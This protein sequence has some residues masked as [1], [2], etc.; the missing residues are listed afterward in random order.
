MAERIKTPVT[1][2]RGEIYL[3][4]FDPVRGREIAKTRPALVIQNNIGNRL[5]DVVIVAALSSIKKDSPHYPVNVLVR[6]PEGGLE[7]DSIV[8]LDQIRSIDKVRISKRI[9][10]LGMGTMEKVDRAIEVSL[11]L[12]E[13]G[14]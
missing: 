1:P 4:T 9:G 3:V 12:I 5:S 2:F 6:S 7:Y 11:G 8:H 14:I 10:I 13:L